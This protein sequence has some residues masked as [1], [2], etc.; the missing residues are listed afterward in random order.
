MT[1]VN[2]STT[3]NTVEVIDATNNV[4]EVSTT[5]PQGP[6]VS[7][8]DKGDVTVSSNGTAIAINTGAVT[9]AK[10]LDGTIVNADINANAAIA[11]SKLADSGVSAGSFGSGSA[12]PTITV[13]DKGIVTAI[14]TNSVNTTT[15]LSTSTSTTDVTIS[16]STGNNASISEA[17][18]SAAGVMSVAQH[19]KL[20]GIQSGATDDQTASEIKTLLNS[21]GIVNAQID[22]SGC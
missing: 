3:K 12:I 20:D 2:I 22:A 17:S 16:S 7:D 19:D 11:N 5:G 18:G 8:G 14:S 10:I 9:S 1:S 15:N 13:N 21:D 4:I 6:T